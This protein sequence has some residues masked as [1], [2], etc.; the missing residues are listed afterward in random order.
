MEA[1]LA[2]IRESEEMTPPMAF[3]IALDEEDVRRQAAA[4]TERWRDNRCERM[5]TL[6]HL[7]ISCEPTL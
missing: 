2:R 3:F 5:A 6:L 4:S 1:T 7:S